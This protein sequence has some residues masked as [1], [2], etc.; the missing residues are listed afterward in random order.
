[1]LISPDRLITELSDPSVRVVE[2][3]VSS[4]AYDEWH[5][6]GAVLWN[7][8]ADMKDE[9]YRPIDDQAVQRLFERS[10]IGPDTTVVC[11]GY[12]PMLGAWLLALHGHVDVRVLNCS[13][14]E[15]R[16]QGHP[17]STGTVRVAPVEYDLPPR[18]PTMFADASEVAGA[19][20]RPGTTILDVRTASEYA[21]E[22]FWHSGGMAPGGR[23]GHIPTALN[24]PLGDLYDRH[25]AF[26]AP[27]DLRRA[28]L[29]PDPRGDD[30]VGDDDLIVYC[31]VGARAATTWFVLTRL[32]GR[33]R[34]R[35]YDG[36]WA[37]WGLRAG[38]AVAR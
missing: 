25:G 7:I 29:P 12:A 14:A 30:L 2:V 31:T 15:W 10:G 38:T 28:V 22:R 16:A 34:V 4:A 11:Y 26:R 23:A 27:D 37:D 19:V 8:Y 32:L 33:S 24:R 1:M 3:D 35:V 36:S 9:Q 18:D 13:R 17:I 5:I 21:G 20:G 6:D